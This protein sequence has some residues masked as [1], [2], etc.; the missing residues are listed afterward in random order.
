MIKKIIGKILMA[1]AVELERLEERV[2]ALRREAIP[3]LSRELLT[4]WERDLGLPDVCSTLAATVE[5]RAQIAHAKYTGNYFGLN[6]DFFIEYAESLGFTITVTEYI[7]AGS[8]F[9]VDVN[10]VD[11]MPLIGVDGARLWSKV[12]KFRWIVTVYSAGD[13][14]LEYLK[15]RFEQ[16]KPAHTEIVWK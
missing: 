13:V 16:L 2:I 5:E 15:C 11:R 4:E 7:G 9:R 8:V 14:S 10:R 6:K 1:F 12:A 3:G